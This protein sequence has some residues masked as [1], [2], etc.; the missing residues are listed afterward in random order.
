[1]RNTTAT[2]EWVVRPSNVSRESRTPIIV[3][4]NDGFF[5]SF[6]F[7]SRLVR[8]QYKGRPPPRRILCRSPT[9]SSR[10]SRSKRRGSPQRK[11]RF[12]R[13]SGNTGREPRLP[14]PIT[15]TT[16]TPTDLPIISVTIYDIGTKFGIVHANIARNENYY[17]IIKI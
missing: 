6:R 10:R 8:V 15:A 7:R 4:S 16:G 14:H 13:N 1:M 5:C 12:D 2:E 11:H 3:D 9:V 17:V